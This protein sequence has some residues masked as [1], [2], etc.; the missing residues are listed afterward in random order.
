MPGRKF[1]HHMRSHLPIL[2]GYLELDKGPRKFLLFMVFNVVSWQCLAGSVLVLF[3]R[4]LEMPSSWVGVLISFMPLSQLLIVFTVPFV[5]RFGPKRMLVGAWISRNLMAMCVLSMP[6]VIAEWGQKGAW[7][8]LICGT[9]GFCVSRAIGTGGWFPWLH[10]M[11]REEQRGT[12]FSTEMAIIHSSTV[13][14]AITMGLLLRSNPSLGKFLCIYTAGILVGFASILRM[15]RVP[16]GKPFPKHE[17]LERGLSSYLKVFSDRPYIHFIVMGAFGLCCLSFVGAAH[18]MY[19]RDAL[20]FS[21]GSIMFLTGLGGLSIAVTVKFWGRYSDKHG[22]VSAMFLTLFGHS[23]AALLWLTLRP[24]AWWTNI[25][26]GPV[27]VSGYVFGAAFW[28]VLHHGMLS[29][30]KEEARICYTNMHLVLLALSVGLTPIVAGQFIQRMGNAG[31]MAC[32]LVSG[33]GGLVIAIATHWIPE[34]GK[35]IPKDVG[36]IL[37]P[38]MPVRTVA[39]LLW[40]TIGLDSSNTPSA[41]KE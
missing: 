12:Y 2:S 16:G 36:Q 18:I 25:L 23:I 35:P 14:A 41:D 40:V 20:K 28:M 31:F 21:S 10:E 30:V 4:H 33:L 37:H 17:H 15:L 24:G 32:F 1:R 8:L 11:I 29:R 6:W 13:V 7:Y 5:E 19:M 9:L 27:L 22:S 38:S 3:A 26:I 39:R 34:D